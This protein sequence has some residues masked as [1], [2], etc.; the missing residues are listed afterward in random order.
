MM[1]S[2]R[3]S[4]PATPTIALD[5]RFAADAATGHRVEGMGDPRGEQ[6]RED[7]AGVGEAPVDRRPADAG[8]AGDLGERHAVDADRRARSS[9]PRRGCGPRPIGGFIVT[10]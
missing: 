9:P 10:D 8:A 5:E 4:R 3:R 2:S 7:R 1:T 6:R